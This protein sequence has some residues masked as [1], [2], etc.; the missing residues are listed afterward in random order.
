MK[1]RTLTREQVLDRPPAEVFPFFADARNL[2][3][4]TPPLLGFRVVGTG[5]EEM[6]V[7][8]LIQYRL[9]IHGL[10][11]DWLTRI[12]QWRPGEAF[13]D[14]QL[15]GPYRLWHHT[16]S[17]EPR[18]GGATLMRDVVRYALPLWPFGELAAP[19]VRRD[20]TAIF[21]FRRAAVA[22]ALS[23]GHDDGSPA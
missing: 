13:V 21:D 20:L 2:E 8:T 16:H 4:I 19:L 9:R 15:A 11:L 1:L 6:G 3:A 22:R 7:G 5:P 14:T 17:F 23:P 10:A 18:A 12:E